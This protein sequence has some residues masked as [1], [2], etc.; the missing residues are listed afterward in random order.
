MGIEMSALRI[1]PT[2]LTFLTTTAIIVAAC[3][4]TQTTSSHPSVSQVIERLDGWRVD[5]GFVGS[6]VDIPVSGKVTVLDFWATWCEPCKLR[7]LPSLERLWQKVDRSRVA[8]AAVSIDKGENLDSLIRKCVAE[9][10]PGGVSFPIVLDG[11]ASILEKAY[12]VRGVIP[13][14]FVIDKKGRV[15][16]YFGGEKENLEHLER[17]VAELSN[18]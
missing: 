17:A 10:I 14:T 2:V 15:R 13:A 18:E 11:S 12:G 8:I 1:I 4:S 5:E 7:I 16:Y 9:E 3:G 6:S